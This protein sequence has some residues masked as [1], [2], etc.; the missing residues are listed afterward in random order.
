MQGVTKM[1]GQATRVSFSKQNKNKTPYKHL[2]G[3]QSFFI[4]IVRPSIL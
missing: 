4:L 2:S 3:N 1:L